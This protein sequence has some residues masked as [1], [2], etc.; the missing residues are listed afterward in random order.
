MIVKMFLM[1]LAYAKVATKIAIFFE[2][3]KTFTFFFHSNAKA[4]TTPPCIR[5]LHDSHRATFSF[6]KNTAVVSRRKFKVS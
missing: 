1:T 6:L 2:T 3:A 5:K 4:V